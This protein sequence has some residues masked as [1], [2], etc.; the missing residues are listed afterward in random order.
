MLT[1]AASHDMV[2]AQV[3]MT[4]DP[5]PG[6]WLAAWLIT[7]TVLE[8]RSDYHKIALV[9]QP[10]TKKTPVICLSRWDAFCQ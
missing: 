9:S 3:P 7:V 8:S 6:G 1:P 4:S 10:A 5:Q 2:S